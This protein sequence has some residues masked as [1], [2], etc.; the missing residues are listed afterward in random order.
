MGYIRQ[1]VASSEQKVK[2]CIVATNIDKKLKY[3]LGELPDI[4]F[5]RYE[6]N[7]SLNKIDTN[8]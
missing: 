6:I 5:Y 4:D 3:A 2:G 8:I 7:F 1:K